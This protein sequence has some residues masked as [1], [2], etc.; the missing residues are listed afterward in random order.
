EKTESK[1]PTEAPSTTET[2]ENK[3]V[4]M[5]DV[6]EDKA[7]EVAAAPAAQSETAAAE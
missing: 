2:A 6:R 5:T 4:P 7:E 3:D 1:E